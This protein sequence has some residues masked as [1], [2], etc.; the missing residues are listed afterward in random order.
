MWA[1]LRVSSTG[2][3]RL[4]RTRKSWGCFLKDHKTILIENKV[5]PDV[6][7]KGNAGEKSQHN[8]K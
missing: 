3:L 4:K 5:P 7:G 6:L 1:L 2:T 8:N